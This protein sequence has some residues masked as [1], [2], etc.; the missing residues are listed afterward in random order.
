[1]QGGICLGNLG[2]KFPRNPRTHTKY[3]ILLHSTWVYYTNGQFLNSAPESVPIESSGI[4]SSSDKNDPANSS[5]LSK[6]QRKKLRERAKK[7][8]AK[9]GTTGE[10]SE[11]SVKKSMNIQSQT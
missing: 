7:L 4:D 11:L 3:F 8:G 6:G 9:P 10:S 1:M 2:T 5:D